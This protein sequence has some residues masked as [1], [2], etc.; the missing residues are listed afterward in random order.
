MPHHGNEEE[1][2]EPVSFRDNRKID[3]ETGQVRGQ[4]DA[5][6]TGRCR[7]QRAGSHLEKE[8]ARARHHDGKGERRNALR[9]KPCAKPDRREHQ[10]RK[11]VADEPDIDGAKRRGGGMA[12]R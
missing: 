1:H 2:Q 8:K 10:R 9:H 11:T 5:G 7:L 3:P 12:R 6:G 4:Q